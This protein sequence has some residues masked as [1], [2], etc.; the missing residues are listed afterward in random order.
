MSITFLCGGGVEEIGC[1]GKL[2]TLQ[3]YY[4]E[5][6][7]IQKSNTEVKSKNLGHDGRKNCNISYHTH[8]F[9]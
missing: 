2:N 5:Y 4:L 1:W 6:S 7:G 9:S 8:S 3:T